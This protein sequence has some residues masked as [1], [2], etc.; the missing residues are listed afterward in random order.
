MAVHGLVLRW[1]VPKF[2]S[3]HSEVSVAQLSVSEALILPWLGAFHG[4]KIASVWIKL[5][6]YYR[7]WVHGSFKS[8]LIFAFKWMPTLTFAHQNRVAY[9]KILVRSSRKQVN[10]CLCIQTGANFDLCTFYHS[11][12]DTPIN[13]HTTQHNMKKDRPVSTNQEPHATVITMGRRYQAHT[14]KRCWG[15][16]V[17]LASKEFCWN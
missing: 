7:I 16:F 12:I 8:P 15:T 6:R 9:I 4:L 11:Y 10:S 14:G 13:T 1:Q 3:L 17:N 2:S 5:H